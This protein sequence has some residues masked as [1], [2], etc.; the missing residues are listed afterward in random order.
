MSR[1]HNTDANASNKTLFEYI[2]GKY[3]AP[4]DTNLA[5][6]LFDHKDKMRTWRDFAE[7]VS[8]STT[9]GNEMNVF[10]SSIWAVCQEFLGKLTD[11]EEKMYTRERGG[12]WTCDGEIIAIR[13]ILKDLKKTFP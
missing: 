5:Q 12:V 8:A 4:D 13:S 11:V 7:C 2:R 6:Y 9:E 1:Q 3:P 10:K